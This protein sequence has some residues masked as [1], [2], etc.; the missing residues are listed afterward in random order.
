MAT[1][2]PWEWFDLSDS[3]LRARLEQ[4]GVGPVDVAVFVRYRDDKHFARQIS[5]ILAR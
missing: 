3:E 5:D 2:T 1:S 4:H